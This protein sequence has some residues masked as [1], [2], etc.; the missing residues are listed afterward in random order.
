MET[1][2][3]ALVLLT[4]VLLWAWLAASVAELF[5]P[6]SSTARRIVFIMLATSAAVLLFAVHVRKDFDGPAPLWL[7]SAQQ[8]P[9]IKNLRQGIAGGFGD[10]S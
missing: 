8:V 1:W 5:V 10:L 2:T 9:K 7:P 3:L 6:L 4:V